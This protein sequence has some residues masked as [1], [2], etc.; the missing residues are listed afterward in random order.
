MVI[1]NW[2]DQVPYVGHKSK[3]IWTLFTRAGSKDPDVPEQACLLSLGSLTR[4][5]VQGRITTDYHAHEN[6]EQVYYFVSGKGKMRIDD[7]EYLVTAGDAMHL[8]PQVRHQVVNDTEDDLE[9]LNI[10]ALMEE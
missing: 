10:T 2:R 8:P 3:I 7:E 9:Y 4:H 1:R 5:V 6:K